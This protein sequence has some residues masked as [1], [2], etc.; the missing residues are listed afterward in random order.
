[1]KFNWKCRL[2][3][4][5]YLFRARWVKGS[6]RRVI[7]SHVKLWIELIIHVLNLVNPSYEYEA[8][9]RIAISHENIQHIMRLLK[10]TY[11]R[12]YDSDRLWINRSQL[13]IH[14][15]EQDMGWYTWNIWIK[16]AKVFTYSLNVCSFDTM[17]I[18]LKKQLYDA[19]GVVTRKVIIIFTLRLVWS[20]WVQKYIDHMQPL[21]W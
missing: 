4:G 5:G 17:K 8:Q 18:A 1:M 7:T 11:D 20:G 16:G 12:D 2:W 3:N 13:I 19:L 10:I 6:N 15:H 9:I 14:N 21:Y